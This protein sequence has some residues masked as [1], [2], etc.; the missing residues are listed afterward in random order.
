M[1]DIQGQQ[2]DYLSFLVAALG[3][4][5]VRIPTPNDTPSLYLIKL[6]VVEYDGVRF[7]LGDPLPLE[8][9]RDHEQHTWVCESKEL[10]ILACGESPEQ[11]VHSFSEDFAMLWEE[12]AQCPDDSLSEDARELKGILLQTVKS[13]VVRYGCQQR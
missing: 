8:L 9:Y 7:E 3:S 1:F 5:E 6:D 13:R 12:I 10:G 2:Q 4:V 11:A